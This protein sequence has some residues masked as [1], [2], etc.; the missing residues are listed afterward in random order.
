MGKTNA[1]GD[2]DEDGADHDDTLEQ[3]VNKDD[4][5]INIMV[6]CV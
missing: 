1:D 4:Q 3:F 2:I 6:G 5:K